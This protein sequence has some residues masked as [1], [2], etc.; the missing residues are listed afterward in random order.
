MADAAFECTDHGAR[1][2]IAAHDWMFTRLFIFQHDFIGHEAGA[3][4]YAHC[5]PGDLE[6]GFKTI[7]GGAERVGLFLSLLIVLFYVPQNT[8][9]AVSHLEILENT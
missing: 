3:A 9:H 7:G 5:N 6:P 4:G 2:R 8:N 1:S